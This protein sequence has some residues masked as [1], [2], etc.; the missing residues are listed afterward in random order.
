MFCLLV[1][2]IFLRLHIPSR[3]IHSTKQQTEDAIL[4]MTFLM[5]VTTYNIF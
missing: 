5:N 3:L 4:Q 1:T 2:G